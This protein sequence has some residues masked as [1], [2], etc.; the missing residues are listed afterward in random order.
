MHAIS[1]VVGVQLHVVH[2]STDRE[3]ETVFDGLNASGLVVIGDPFFN[4]RS[5]QLALSALRYAV[6]AAYQFR[7]LTNAGGLISYGSSLLDAHRL[8]G[9]YTGRVLKGEMPANLPVQ[10]SAKVELIINKK[11]AKAIGVSIPTSLLVRAD[12]IIE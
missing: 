10:Q 8:M 9:I 6:P 12:E 1:S 4:C 2:A 11:T 5:E 3:L 7:E